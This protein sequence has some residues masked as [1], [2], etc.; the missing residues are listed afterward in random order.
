MDRRRFLGC[1]AAVGAGLSGT[2]ALAGCARDDDA[3][4]F[5][6]QARPEEARVRMRI[7][8]AFQRRHPDIRVRT[9]LS[10]PDPLQQMLTYCAGGKCPDVLMAWELLYAGLADRGVLLDLNTM[11]GRD[12]RYAAQLRADSAPALYDTFAFKGAQYALPEQWSGVFLFYNTALFEQAGV[13][14]P[15]ARW[16]EAWTFAEF[17][18]AAQA[19][20]K[21]DRSGRIARYGFVDAWV[22]YLSAAC[23][24]MNN[25]AEWFRPAVNPTAHGLAD[26]R[27][28]AGFQFYADLAIKHRVAPKPA[29]VQA[30]STQDLFLSGRAGMM[31]GGHWLYSE[32]VGADNLPFD[33][34]VLPVGPDAGGRASKSDVGTTGLAIAAGS[35]RREQAWEFVRFATGPEGQAII[36][37]SG[38]FVPVLKSVVHSPA[39]AA[40]HAGVR[41]LEVFTG[42][43]DNSHQFPVTPKWGE[44]SATLDRGFNKVLRGAATADSFRHGLS[45]DVDRLLGQA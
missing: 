18:A 38:L 12:P 1:A 27:F 40:A 33:V 21:R 10:G 41:N 31:M 3:L 44:V 37:D 32:V 28:T 29:E 24:G 8:D 9:V 13:A 26:P 15:P 19:I 36:A 5:F 25:G 42:G 11:L 34:T 6:F 4:T 2:A 43:L 20:T 23:F 22:P 30:V 17:L 14:P 35:P 16:T 45:A 7:I 39:F